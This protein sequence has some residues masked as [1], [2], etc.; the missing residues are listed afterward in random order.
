MNEMELSRP[1]QT[2]PFRRSPLRFVFL[3]SLRL[4]EIEVRAK[5]RGNVPPTGCDPS[6]V[7]SISTS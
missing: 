5:R 7:H 4:E 6:D 2:L 1:W 3:G